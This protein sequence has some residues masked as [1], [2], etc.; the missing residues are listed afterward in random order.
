MDILRKNKKEM[1]EIRK[2]YLRREN[3]LIGLISRLDMIEER[4]SDLEDM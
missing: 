2:H 4:I 1:L 3:A